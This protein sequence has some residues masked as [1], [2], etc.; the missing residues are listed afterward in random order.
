[1]NNW[2]TFDLQWSIWSELIGKVMGELEPKV[3]LLEEKTTGSMDD[4]IAI[5]LQGRKDFATP[6]LTHIFGMDDS[7]NARSN[8]TNPIFIISVI[9][10]FTIDSS[11]S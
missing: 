2:S 4:S 6:L 8:D 1:M 5:S 9:I 11:A 10:K 7:V 3:W